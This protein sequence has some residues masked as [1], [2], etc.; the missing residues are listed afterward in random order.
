MGTSLGGVI[1]VTLTL[2]ETQDDRVLCLQSVLAVASGEFFAYK[3]EHLEQFYNRHDDDYMT[4]NVFKLKGSLQRIALLDCTGALMTLPHSSK[5]SGKQTVDREPHYVVM[6]SDKS[7]RVVT[8]P[9]QVT[10]YKVTL[11]ESSFVVR[12]DVIQIKTTGE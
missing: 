5:T 8:L 3:V 2:P 12:A 7:A 10:A 4:G 11:S 1:I 6:V 9:S